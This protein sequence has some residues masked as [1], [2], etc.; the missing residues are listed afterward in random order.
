MARRL[1]SSARFLGDARTTTF[2]RA[3]RNPNSQPSS[4]RTVDAIR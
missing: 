1:P 3:G 2:R 4:R